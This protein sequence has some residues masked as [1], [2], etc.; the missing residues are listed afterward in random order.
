MKVEMHY[1]MFDVLG[2]NEDIDYAILAINYRVVKKK[3]TDKPQYQI[4]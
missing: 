1:M 4:K 2:F 3:L